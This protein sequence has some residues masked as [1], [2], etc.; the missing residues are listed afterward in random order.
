ML[1]TF[2]NI[3][4]VT[5]TVDPELFSSPREAYAYL[6]DRDCVRNTILALHRN[7]LTHSPRYFSV[8]EWQEDT[9]Q[10]HYHVL[11]DATN[12]P[13]AKLYDIWS[14]RRPRSAGPVAPGRHPFGRTDVSPPRRYKGGKDEAAR[15]AAYYVTKVPPKGFPA[16][17]MAM[18]A[19]ERIRRFSTNQGFWNRPRPAKPKAAPRTPTA[20][21]R[22]KRQKRSYAERAAD[23][24][25]TSNVFESATRVDYE[26]GEEIEYDR[27]V[28]TLGPVGGDHANRPRY[29]AG[30]VQARSLEGVLDVYEAEID[31]PA[32]IKRTRRAKP[33]VDQRSGH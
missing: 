19:D 18:G 8:V 12:I 30:E 6:R 11:L 5:L 2:T 1:L 9:E 10:V 33:R 3:T 22:T 26:T 27:Y 14:R 32:E 16:W 24:G 28:G 17:V 15:R 31:Q 13:E 7:K 21:R 20:N 29:V 25:T 4:M 23:C